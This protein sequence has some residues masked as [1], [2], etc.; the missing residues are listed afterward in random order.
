MRAATAKVAVRA[1]IQ[2]RMS[3]RRFPGKVLAPYRGRPRITHVLS[4]I[5]AAF[6]GSVPLS[7]LTGTDRPDDPLRVYLDSLGVDVWRGPLDDVYD[8]FRQCLEARPCE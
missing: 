4:A 6:G 7:V 2:A 5:D 8:R 1:F 3:S